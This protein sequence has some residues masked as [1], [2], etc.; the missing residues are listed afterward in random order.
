MRSLK[1]LLGF[2]LVLAL[3]PGT[4]AQEPALDNQ[5]EDG[6]TLTITTKPFDPKMHKIEKCGGELACTA[7]DG[8]LKRCEKNVCQ[9]D[10]RPLYGAYGKMPKQEVTSLIFEKNGKK[11]A[12]D[13]SGMYNPNV[14]N[15]NIKKYVQ[16][17]S[18]G[19]DSYEITGYFSHDD[20]DDSMYICLWSV[21][22]GGSFR[23]YMGDF[24]ALIRLADTAKEDFNYVSLQEIMEQNSNRKDKE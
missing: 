3:V 11:I 16:L 5:F 19:K 14:N 22:P 8:S 7:D 2:A 17:T 13:V 6:V 18:W 4:R 24:S 10:G 20:G 1:F 23:N 12:L 15:S 21:W 9:I